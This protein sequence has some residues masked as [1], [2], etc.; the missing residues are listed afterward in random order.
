[1]ML[2]TSFSL[3]VV[4][5][6]QKNYYIKIVKDTIVNDNYY[7]ENSILP[8]K[9]NLDEGVNPFYIR[10]IAV[11]M[12]KNTTETLQKD[13]I[14]KVIR[15]N[16]KLNEIRF[17]EP[18]NDRLRY[19]VSSTIEL[20]IKVGEDFIDYSYVKLI[21]DNEIKNNSTNYINTIKSQCSYNEN[22]KLLDLRNCN[23]DYVLNNKKYSKDTQPN[24]YPDTKITFI[25]HDHPIITLS[26]KEFTKDSIDEENTDL[27]L[28]VM[29]KE[30]WYIVAIGI[31]GL[32]FII[33]LS[34]LLL[35]KKRSNRD[36]NNSYDN[37]DSSISTEDCDNVRDNDSRNNG[38]RNKSK[39]INKQSQPIEK[40]DNSNKVE[41]KE[42][43]SPIVDKQLFDELKNLLNSVNIVVTETK[44]TIETQTKTLDG[45]KQLVSNT[46]D[47]KQLDKKNQELETVKTKLKHEEDRYDK[48]I[49]E[50]NNAISDVKKLENQ[51]AE[52]QK[53]TQI[54][55]TVQISEYSTFVSFAKKIISECTE[56]ENIAIRYWSSLPNKDQQIVNCFLSNFQ[57]A[58]CNTDLTKWN[59]IIAT[60]DLKGYIKNDEYIKYLTP[61]SDKERL[62][63]I[64]KRFFEEILRPYVGAIVLFLE[65]IRT[66]TKIGVSKACKDNIE[67]FINSIC[68]KCSEQ[69]V[70]IDYKKLYERV[71]EYD[72]LEIEENIPDTMKG[73][74]AKIEK[75]D[76]L[77]YVDKYA[78]NLKS[79]E[80]TEK[81]RCYIKI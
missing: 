46:D 60:L 47:K 45:I 59:G 68:T 51:I 21:P 62:A 67:G 25:I 76:V 35:N 78:V 32:C 16:E 58:K 66:V 52:L 13:G 40:R 75:E 15:Y 61:L 7:H 10:V 37:S 39:K 53:D 33:V 65:Q 5:Q 81:T 31:L 43:T 24:I 28:L 4:A 8:D 54:K 3:K 6:E 55:G 70:L 63:F 19:D 64:N 42:T 11:D 50:K 69:N 77:L 29:L 48:A 1:M 23:Y 27:N 72:S 34:L 18:N 36:R 20:L 22:E 71:T 57:M 41:L 74:I 9:I 80:M 14:Y 17:S 26:A 38:S 56:A 12:T 2:V 79:G 49:A 73:I 44:K 30:H